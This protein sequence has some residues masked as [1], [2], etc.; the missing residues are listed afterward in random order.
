MFWLS[1][2]C[3]N[4][5]SIEPAKFSI[6]GPVLSYK[7]IGADLEEYTSVGEFRSKFRLEESC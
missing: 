7:E 6:R 3:P 4:A 2:H 5:K 1:T